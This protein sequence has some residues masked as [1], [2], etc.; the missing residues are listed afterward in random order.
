M[1]EQKQPPRD[2]EKARRLRE[3]AAEIRKGLGPVVEQLFEQRDVMRRALC[4]ARDLLQM[5]AKEN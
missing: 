4:A 2:V 1:A 5:A 3:Q